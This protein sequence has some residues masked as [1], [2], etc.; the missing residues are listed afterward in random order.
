[1]LDAVGVQL[2]VGYLEVDNG[3]YLHGDVILGDNGLGREIGYLLLE[4]DGLRDSLK[5]GDLDMDAG[6]PGRLIFAQALDYHDLALLNDADISYDYN[7][8][9]K[10]QYVNYIFHLLSP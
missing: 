5:E 7:K 2:G 6:A 9:K 3:V 10:Y 4:G 8:H 1:M